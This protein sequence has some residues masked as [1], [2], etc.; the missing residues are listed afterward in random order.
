MS[1]ELGH[2]SALPTP[3]INRQMTSTIS[4]F[5]QTG[6]NTIQFVKSD[7][8]N[9]APKVALF[10][11]IVTTIMSV[12]VTSPCDGFR[13]FLPVV[14]SILVSEEARSSCSQFARALRS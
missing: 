7:A 8:D 10:A 9:I 5:K 3:R 12:V 13:R 6:R 4:R 2:G 11:I 1:T 14:L